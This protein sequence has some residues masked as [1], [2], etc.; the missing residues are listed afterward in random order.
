MITFIEK[1]TPTQDITFYMQNNFNKV[2]K[3][4]LTICQSINISNAALFKNNNKD[5]LLYL[6][7][8]YHP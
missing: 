6:E 7:P 2:F 1:K 5:N 4:A 8:Y 3:K